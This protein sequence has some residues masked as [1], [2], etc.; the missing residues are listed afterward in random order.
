MLGLG[1]AQGLS[2]CTALSR[3]LTYSLTLL[4]RHGVAYFQ[5]MNRPQD[6]SENTKRY[7]GA[8]HVVLAEGACEPC[9]VLCQ[10]GRCCGSAPHPGS[11]HLSSHMRHAATTSRRM[12][13]QASALC[14]AGDHDTG[15]AARTAPGPYVARHA[16][17][18]A[19]SAVILRARARIAALRSRCH[20]L[21]VVWD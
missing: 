3:V 14:A 21:V 1:E 9:L 8:R 10:A 12:M 20:S 19:G 6:A 5:Q 4:I 16:C 2:N 15:C 7:S 18:P 13:R 11:Q 17:I